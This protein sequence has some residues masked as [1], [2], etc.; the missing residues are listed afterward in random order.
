M[1]TPNSG[2]FLPGLLVPWTDSL[3]NAR[4]T[5]RVTLPSACSHNDI[6]AVISP[7]GREVVITYLW[8][9]V[10][11]NPMALNEAY[12]ELGG[13]LKYPLNHVKITAFAKAVREARE[14]A[15]SDRVSSIFW[16]NLPFGCQEKFTNAEGHDGMEYLQIHCTRTNLVLIQLNLEL[17]GLHTSYQPDKPTLSVRVL[18]SPTQQK[19]HVGAQQLHHRGDSTMTGGVNFNT[20]ASGSKKAGCEQ[21]KTV[22]SPT[23][24]PFSSAASAAGWSTYEDPCCGNAATAAL[25]RARNHRN[26]SLGNDDCIPPRQNGFKRQSVEIADVQADKNPMDVELA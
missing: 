1:N 20:S 10:L 11:M 4:I 8:S 7:G 14:S 5:I 6:D 15:G 22:F 13:G 17:M 16:I 19:Q 24:F 21:S 26:T 9:D 23:T 18:A 2:N 12:T 3:T 25:N